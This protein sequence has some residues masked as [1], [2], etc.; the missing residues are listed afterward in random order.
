M[1]RKTLWA[2]VPLLLFIG[3]AVLL[4]VNLGRDTEELPA[5]LAGKPLPRLALPSLLRQGAVVSND[6]LPD[7]FVLLNV[8]ATWCPACYVEHPFLLR[9]AEQGVRIVGLNYKDAPD[10]ART[11]LAEGG[12]PYMEVVFDADGSYGLEL[13]VYGA[14]ETWLLHDGNIVLRHAGELNARVWSDRFLPVMNAGGASR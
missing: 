3:L 2:F 9:L 12:N 5:A 10:K 7:G 1:S 8:W 6:D 13:G 14:P 4:A 11:Y